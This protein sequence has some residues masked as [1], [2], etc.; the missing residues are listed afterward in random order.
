MIIKNGHIITKDEVLKNTDIRIENG[1]IAEIGKDLKG[2]DTYDA[3]GMYV[4]PGFVDIH[5]HGGFGSD[6]MD[7]DDNAINT[8]LD[9]HTGNGTTSLLA[10]T[11]TAPV[12]QI[13]SMIERV[14]K[15]MKSEDAKGKTKILGVHI[16]G[17]YISYKNKG[18]QKEEFLKV[19]SKDDYSFI[20]NNSDIIKNV[21]ISTE[22]DGA[23]KMTKDLVG[24]GI[25]VSLGHDDGKSETAYPVIDAGATNLTHWYCAMSTA[26]VEDGKRSAGLMEIGLVD[27]RL[28]LELLADTHHLPPELVHLA[29]KCKGADKLSLVSDCLRAGGM[30]RDGR[31]YTLGT[32]GDEDATK[33]IVS[34]GVARLTDGT[35]FAGS[36]QPVRQMVKNVMEACDI[37]LV[38]AVKMASLTPAGVIGMADKIGSLEVGKIADINILTPELEPVKTII[39]GEFIN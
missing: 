36:I 18:A 33:F 1:I 37:P 28:T 10:S 29:Y 38:D 14:R 35:R 23:E 21:T 9:F 13:E 32:L 31:V 7:D 16:E 11:V 25:K 3:T 15:H 20:L 27:S 30:P 39:D 17:P 5:T 34:N 24:A 6:F 2:D 22:L 12:S 8:V 4:S 19:P 26:R